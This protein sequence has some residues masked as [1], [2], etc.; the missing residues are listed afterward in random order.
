MRALEDNERLY[1]M[2]AQKKVPFAWCPPES[3]RKRQFSHA[4]DV[5]A[6]GVTLW[7][8][9][10]YG[11]EPWAGCRGAEVYF[12]QCFCFLL[13]RLS[14][15][16]MVLTKTEAGERLSRPLRCSNEIYDLMSSCWLPEAEDRPRFSLLRSLLSDIK[17]MIA[18]AREECLSTQQL[19]LELKANDR[20]IVIDGRNARILGPQMITSIIDM[21]PS[22]RTAA[23]AASD[24]N[25]QS[26]SKKPKPSIPTLG[27]NAPNSGG[28]WDDSA[29][30]RSQT[31]PFSP[32]SDYEFDVDEENIGNTIAELQ[33]QS[34]QQPSVLEPIVVAGGQVR[35]P[36][37]L[38]DRET[39]ANALASLGAAKAVSPKSARSHSF[40]APR[41]STSTASVTP[42]PPIPP[43]PVTHHLK[44]TP[45]PVETDTMN[46]K[47]GTFVEDVYSH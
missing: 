47:K 39:L 37:A 22:A 20:V 21:H 16:M 36:T 4:S 9:F 14:V 11:D 26:S 32:F 2:S 40:L 28:H 46:S 41:A 5:W 35:K 10:S 43:Q 33:Q 23:P 38:V 1:V 7:E 18:E 12:L 19:S 13:I 31:D 17:F 45:Q 6:F 34:Q 44:P 42:A 29:Q 8:M 3:L 24:D 15:L 30:S 27:P 25:K